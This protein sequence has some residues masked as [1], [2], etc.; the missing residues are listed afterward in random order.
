MRASSSP[1]LERG[2]KGPSSHTLTP[3]TPPSDLRWLSDK[4]PDPEAKNL[5]GI[6]LPA[7]EWFYSERVRQLTYNI[8]GNE[9]RATDATGTPLSDE[10][11]MAAADFAVF[12]DT[13]AIYQRFE[14]ERTEAEEALFQRGECMH[15]EPL[16]FLISHWGG[17]CRAQGSITS[18]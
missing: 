7:L 3:A 10:A 15:A 17:H 2:S 5:R 9:E 8:Y 4:H 11:V 16:Y 12:I 1:A 13:V 14:R 6:W 18:T